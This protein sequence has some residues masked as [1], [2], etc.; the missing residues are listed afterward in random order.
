MNEKSA[1]HSTTI[2]FNNQLI[3]PFEVFVN[4]TALKML[5]YLAYLTILYLNLEEITSLV[6]DTLVFCNYYPAY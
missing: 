1:V 4:E 5:T 3:Q 2:L 6:W